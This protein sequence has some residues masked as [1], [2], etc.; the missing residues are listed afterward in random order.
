MRRSGVRIPSAPPRRETPSDQRRCASGGVFLVLLVLRRTP[1]ALPGFAERPPPAGHRTASACCGSA[2]C[3]RLGRTVLRREAEAWPARRAPRVG[4]PAD[5]SGLGLGC[6]LV[7]VPGCRHQAD[8]PV[9][10]CARLGL[11]VEGHA[12]DRS[13]HPGAGRTSGLPRA[14][15]RSGIRDRRGRQS[16]GRDAARRAPPAPA[17][18]RGGRLGPRSPSGA[19]AFRC[20][21]RLRARR[22]LPWRS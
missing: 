2:C 6:R 15:H 19:A 21:R 7:R 1:T 10:P 13:A 5:S 14:R 4:A 12:E 3:G 22:R 9:T 17:D 18:A 16:R 20:R 11:R 8:R